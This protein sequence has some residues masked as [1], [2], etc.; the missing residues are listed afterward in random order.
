MP[1]RSIARIGDETIREAL[2]EL[3]SEFYRELRVA[4]TANAQTANAG[5]STASSLKEHASVC[6]EER[7]GYIQWQESLER[8]LQ[9][10]K[11][12]FQAHMQADEEFQDKMDKKFT[13]GL[14]WLIGT[15]ASMVGGIGVAALTGHLAIH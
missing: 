10:F 9:E 4:S 3:R 13:G 6:A 11:S 5:A 7:R 14:M 2:L 1:D 12:A 15:L 8:I